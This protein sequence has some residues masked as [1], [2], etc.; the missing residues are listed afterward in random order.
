VPLV[1]K[2]VPI[3]GAAYVL[4]PLD[5]LPD[6]IPIVGQIDDL[7]FLLIALEGFLRLCPTEAVTFHRAAIDEGR[8]YSRMHPA[9]DF[10]DAEW[11][12]G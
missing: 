5:F 2:A 8:R 6:V 4:F 9:G 10:I 3:L 11:R 7:G 12:R 1:A